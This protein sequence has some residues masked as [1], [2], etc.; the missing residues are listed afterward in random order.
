MDGVAF[1]LAVLASWRIARMIIEDNGPF[2]IFGRFRD[3][4][5]VEGLPTPGSLADLMG[6]YYCLSMY[7]SIP[8]AAWLSNDIPSFFV[9]WLAVSAGAAGINVIMKRI[10]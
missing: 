6:C 2:N 4:I 1:L 10:E 8:F 7:T 5:G 9:Y 3:K